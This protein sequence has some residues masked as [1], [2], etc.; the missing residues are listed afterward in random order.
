MAPR[1]RRPYSPAE[2]A[3]QKR[4]KEERRL[5]VESLRERG[6]T[7][8]C[9]DAWNII[10]TRRLDVFDLLLERKTITAPQQAAVRRLETIVAQAFGH[11]KPDMGLE[12]VSAT[13][14]GAPGQN[15]TQAMIDA[16][17]A[18]RD[19][20]DLVGKR[21]A[22]LIWALITNVDGILT[23]WRETV[24]RITGEKT[25]PARAA[26]VRAALENLCEAFRATDYQQRDKRI[27]EA[28]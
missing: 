27:R 15:I 2:Q 7:V 23:R 9:D 22:R 10:V 8:T 17:T 25:P 28:L 20:L 3:E 24:T 6:L 11:E 21:D 14:E 13:A 26:A 1:R 16:A 18:L 4:L 19:V 12:R 5:Y